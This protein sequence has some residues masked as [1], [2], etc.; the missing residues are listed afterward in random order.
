MG[1]VLRRLDLAAYFQRL[2]KDKPHLGWRYSQQAW[3]SY[4]HN[5][6]ARLLLQRA[7]VASGLSDVV[8]NEPAEDLLVLRYPTLGH[9]SCHHDTSSFFISHK[10]IRLG[11]LAVFLNTPKEGGELAF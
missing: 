10:Q 1:K 11:T 9:Y 3:L 8:F 4:K 6:V 5:A 7:K 2:L